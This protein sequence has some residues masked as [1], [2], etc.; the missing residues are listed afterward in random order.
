MRIAVIHPGAQFSTHD[1]YIGV[2]GG[3]RASGV[4]VVE[5]RLDTILN[6]YAAT[7]AHAVRVGA[8]TEAALDPDHMCYAALA[9]A[10]VTRHVLMTEPELVLVVSGHNFHTRDAVA[11]RRHGY[12]V[13]VLLTESPYFGETETQIAACYDVA[14]TNERRAVASFRARGVNAHYLPHAYNPDIH[15]LDGPTIDNPPDAAFVGTLFDERKALFGAGDWSD[16]RFL[17]YGVDP[18][19][20][21][22][23]D[24]IDNA[25]AAA[26]YRSA[27]IN[28]NHHRTTTM[29]GSGEHIAA[30]T[31]ESLGPRAYEIAACG[32][33]QLM[34]DGRSE[35][36][37]V[38]GDALVTY[39]AGDS[40]DLGRQV[41]WW[42]GDAGARR[43]YAGAQHAAIQPHSWHR[44]A[45]ELLERLAAP[46]PRAWSILRQ[47]TEAAVGD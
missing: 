43:A 14:F 9:S 13:G 15:R 26:I 42:L 3:L 44:R 28:I 17:H 10:H 4:D 47:R 45:P 5:C 39:R 23:E 27:A 36:R 30:A 33:F 25:H 29:H 11:L 32:G 35:A 20:L 41:R 8:M 21:S 18:D 12:R 31:A 38:F 40:A 2:V 46:A 16:L 6:W 22:A 19:R 34:D 1:V 24:V 7:S 37:D